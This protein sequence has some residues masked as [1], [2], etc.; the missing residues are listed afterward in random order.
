MNKFVATICA[1]AAAM[2][3]ISAEAKQPQVTG[4]AL[5]QIQA[6]DY[7]TSVDILFPAIVSVLQDSGYRITEADRASGFVSGTGSAEGKLSFNILWGFGQKK[8]IPMV[9]AFVEQRGPNIARVR[10]NF[11][12]SKAKSRKSYSD[13]TP[14]TDP[15]AYKEAFELIEKEVFVRQAMNAAGPQPAIAP[16]VAATIPASTTR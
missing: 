16:P 7:E 6:K 3:S 11:V 1:A 5:Q 13:E 12:L 10:L 14:V 2:S 15:Q 4:L 8:D 9:S